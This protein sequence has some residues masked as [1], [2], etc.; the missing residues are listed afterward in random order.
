ML[1]AEGFRFFELVLAYN[2]TNLKG[3]VL[4]NTLV[5]Y[6][7]CEILKHMHNSLACWTSMLARG[8]SCS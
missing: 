7:L 8:R 6:A 5:T 2:K 4:S 1:N 3:L